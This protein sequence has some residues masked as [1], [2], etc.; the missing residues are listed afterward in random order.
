MRDIVIEWGEMIEHIC[1]RDL[2]EA[3]DMAEYI[4]LAFEKSAYLGRL[5]SYVCSKK[6]L[7]K[8]EV[9]RLIDQSTAIEHNEATAMLLNYQNKYYPVSAEDEDDDP[10]FLPSLDDGF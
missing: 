8:N 2:L 7:E 4:R 6:K 1:S 10:F 5:L 9:N 3:K